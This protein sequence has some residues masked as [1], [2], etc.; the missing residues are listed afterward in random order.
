MTKH[1]PGECWC[2]LFHH[3]CHLNREADRPYEEEVCCWCGEVLPILHIRPVED[4]G[5]HAPWLYNPQHISPEQD[6]CPGLVQR[7]SQLAEGE[8][9][10]IVARGGVLSG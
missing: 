1:T 9:D 6:I 7:V 4:H 10:A 2:G 3:C 8:I 5:P